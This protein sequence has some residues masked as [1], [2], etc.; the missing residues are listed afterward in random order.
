V[1]ARLVYS[2]GQGRICAGCGWP[3]E[4]CHC[5]K[6]LATPDEAV[7]EKITVRLRV[8]NRGPGKQVT[9]LAGLPRNRAYLETLC[10]SLKKSCGTGGSAGED[11]IELQGDQRERLRELLEKK[12]LGVKG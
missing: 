1:A 8:E 2:S 10:R 11:A 7:P 4:D 6:S 9:V 5:A 3:S 12:G